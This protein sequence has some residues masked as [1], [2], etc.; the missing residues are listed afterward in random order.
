MR[1]QEANPYL[2]MVLNKGI[3][4][5][6]IH[7]RDCGSNTTIYKESQRNMVELLHRSFKIQELSQ[8]EL[9]GWP[10]KHPVICKG[11]RNRMKICVI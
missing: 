7:I 2:P 4:W 11:H 3:T 8:E 10:L 5:S 6:S 1:V 9:I